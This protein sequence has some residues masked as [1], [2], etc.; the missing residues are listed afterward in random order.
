M[1]QSFIT[2]STTTTTIAVATTT[3]TCSLPVSG[4]ALGQV[5]GCTCPHR[6]RCYLECRRVRSSDQ[7]SSSFTSLTCCSWWND[8]VFIHTAMQTTLRSTGFVTRLMLMHCNSVCRSAS[9]KSSL[10]W[11]LTGC[12]SA[13]RRLKCSGVHLLDVSIR[14]RLVLFVLV[15]HLCCRYEQFKTWGSTPVSYTHLTL[16]TIYSV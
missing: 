7:S 3:T 12:N 15:T 16:P 8:M 6:L 9:M 2:Y 1:R 5:V 11:C 14:S 10:G 13:L 4:R